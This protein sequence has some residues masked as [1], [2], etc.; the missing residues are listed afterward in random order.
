[1]RKISIIV[2]V[3]NAEKYLERGLSSLV[4][5][6]IF[7]ELEIIIV[8]D[9]STDK[10]YEICKK[11]QKKYNNIFVYTKKNEG[12]SSARNYGI[13]KASCEY[14]CF[15]DA[16][17]TVE[18]DMYE[19]LLNY[20]QKSKADIAMADFNNIFIRKKIKKRKNYEIVLC[21]DELLK[22]FFKGGIIGNNIVDKI[23][24]KKVIKNNR[25]YVGMAI[26]EDMYFIYEVLKQTNY[27]YINTFYSGYNY[28]KNEDSSMNS[29]F[30]PKFFDTIELSKHMVNDY[31][32]E[33]ELYDYA[34]A[35]FIHEVCK[36]IEYMIAKDK[37]KA[38]IQKRKEYIK[39][40][41]NYSIIKAYKFLSKR[42]FCGLILMKISPKVY[43]F[44]LK[45]MKIA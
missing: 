41:K 17:D 38:Y 28:Y 8:N 34:Y 32:L 1:M 4:N 24:S 37:E 15:F 3:Y 30:S 18:K 9:G 33:D 26:G 10:S 43:M 21:K 35:H 27:M 45:L 6:T 31:N 5:Q 40:L 25:F 2:P 23:F 36:V 14:I 20:I 13:E 16:D 29:K 11:F 42:Q 7:E 44:F 12:V 22:I 19:M 39:I